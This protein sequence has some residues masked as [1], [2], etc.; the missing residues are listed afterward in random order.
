MTREELERI[1]RDLDPAVRL[2][3]PR[4]L[5]RVIKQDRGLP[6]FLYR[7]P[8]RKSYLISREALLEIVDPEECGWPAEEE[9]PEKVILLTQPDPQRLEEIPRDAVLQFYWRLLFHARVHGAI[10]QCFALGFLSETVVRKRVH[11]IGAGAFEEA[12]A[13]L[14][15]ENFLLPPRDEATTYEEFA[16]LFF[17]LKYFAW[18]ALPVYFPAVDAAAAAA[19]LEQDV[20]AAGLF[21]ATRL[22]GAPD[23]VDRALSAPLDAWAGDAEEPTAAV[24]PIPAA[25]PSEKRFRR[26][27]R[28]AQEPAKRGNLVGAICSR[29]KAL[30]YAPSALAGKIRHALKDDVHQL[31]VRL[32]SALDFPQSASSAWQESLQVL[33]YHTADGYWTPEARIL[34]DL[35]KVCLDHEREIYTVDLLGWLRTLGRRPIRRVLSAQRELLLAQHLRR[36]ERRLALV[37]LTDARRKLLGDL[38]HEAGRQVES[39]LRER[40]RPMM[41]RALNAVGLRPENLPESIAQDKLVE[42]LLDRA[43]DRGFL[44]FGDLRDALSRNHLKL[45]DCRGAGELI[46]GDPLLKADRRLGMVLEG[47]Y[48]PAEFYL[49]WMQRLSALAFGTPFG[50]L[51]TLLVAVPFG[52]AYLIQKGLDHLLAFFF[53]D[54]HAFESPY[55][56]VIFGIFLCGLVNFHPFR[57]LVARSL[58]DFFH[59]LNQWLFQP[60]WHAIQ[61]HVV[62]I[63]LHNRAF[64]LLFRFLIKPALWTLAV[65]ILFPPEGIGWQATTTTAVLL[66]CSAN[67]I[68][69]SRFGRTLEEIVSD[70]VVQTWQ[71][72]GLRLIVGLFWLVVDF[73][74]TLLETVERLMYAV[75]EWLRFRRGEEARLLAVKGVLG[76]LWF[77]VAYLVRFCVNLLIE[78]QINPIKHF[79]VVTVSH[80][81]LLPLT[82]ALYEVFKTHF[83]MERGEA[84]FFATLIIISIPGIF[85]FLVWELKENWRLYAANRP[86]GLQ[87]AAIGA[88]GETLARLLRPGFHSG[89]IPKLFA[90]L[91]RAERK[92]RK[93]GNWRAVRKNFRKLQHV[94]QSLCRFLDREFIA[95][96]RAGDFLLPDRGMAPGE[97][98]SEDEKK[99]EAASCRF[100][101]EPKRQDAAS[102]FMPPPAF[103]LDAIHFAT[104]RVRFTLAHPSMPDDPLI[105]VIEVRMG[106]IVADVIASGWADRLPK[107]QTDLFSRALSGFYK[108]LGVDL[109]RQQI[110]ANFP[111]PPP[112]L[113]FDA[114]GLR[115]WTD[116]TFE[117][118][119]FYAITD[120]PVWEPQFP[121][122]HLTMK[123]PPLPRDRI[124]FREFMYPWNDWVALWTRENVPEVAPAL[125]P[126][127]SVLPPAR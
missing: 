17:E 69:N 28:S 36:A 105:L 70:A 16:A 99:M 33:A 13:V 5:R 111:A 80:K 101:A 12:R 51:L 58:K 68:L 18:H 127:L 72:Y 110:V 115:L 103:F 76:V 40:F 41:E 123:F 24:A 20:D 119:V 106:W 3:V 64:R 71:R 49:R 125:I 100:T 85:G 81:L 73:F 92:A 88:H 1:L 117:N 62:Q 83:R 61:S 91:R 95:L 113:D 2:V 57:R 108:T 34:Y 30:R 104:Q 42:E 22:P 84:W 96:L 8:H 74:K 118:D 63:I 39:R 90:K 98:R 86:A 89:T 15:Q 94:E 79:P 6:G 19:V 27:M 82:P 121:P 38:L 47:V 9:L 107:S 77:Y 65:W 50:R 14:Q 31:T 114:H 25:A 93:T 126:N 78:P 32:Q 43:A 55:P 46:Y 112:P 44:T 48:R 29:A 60:F 59:F 122:Q 67:L 4:I 52:G 54:V 116:A 66:F 21:E 7:V 11:Q 35:Q 26:W 120:E 124:F 45:P 23:P 10:G 56:I 102:T 75:D 53:K 37:R 97:G 109:I 87:A